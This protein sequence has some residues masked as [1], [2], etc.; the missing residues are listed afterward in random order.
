MNNMNEFDVLYLSKCAT[1]FEAC[2]EVGKKVSLEGIDKD[3]ALWF[4]KNQRELEL[5]SLLLKRL[6]KEAVIVLANSFQNKKT[7]EGL[8]VL[9]RLVI[10]KLIPAVSRMAYLVYKSPNSAFV[11]MLIDKHPMLIQNSVIRYR[12]TKSG[13]R[14]VVVIDHE[15]YVSSL[16]KLQERYDILLDEKLNKDTEGKKEGVINESNN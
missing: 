10:T 16:M 9:K 8:L 3:S 5:M 1:F 7:E 15:K 4:E 13:E 2:T 11:S 12:I 14:V 6:S